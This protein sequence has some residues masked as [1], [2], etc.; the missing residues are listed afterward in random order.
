MS[1]SAVLISANVLHREVEN[2]QV[3]RPGSPLNAMSAV[4]VPRSTHKNTGRQSR[5]FSD[6]LDLVPSDSLADVFTFSAFTVPLL[7][8]TKVKPGST[9]QTQ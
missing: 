6:K 5:N 7:S 3:Y 9:F 4:R 8:P 1:M 2:S